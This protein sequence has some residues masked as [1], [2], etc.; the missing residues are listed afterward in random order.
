MVKTIILDGSKTKIDNLGDRNTLIVNNSSGTVY[1]SATP[2]VEPFA[3]NVITIKAGQRD[4]IPETYGTVYLLGSGSV[5]LRGVRYVNFNQP[6]SQNENSS[7]DGTGV[8][9]SYVDSQDAATLQASKIYTNKQ[10]ATP[11]DT[12]LNEMLNEIFKKGE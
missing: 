11:T 6:A 8:S 4:I 12:E 9:Q 2:N 10:T 1:A 5:E 7:S 3:D